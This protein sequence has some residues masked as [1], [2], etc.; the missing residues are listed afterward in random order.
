MKLLPDKCQMCN[1]VL[2]KV[3]PFKTTQREIVEFAQ[4]SSLPPSERE[5]IIRHRW[6]H[7]GL[8]CP[9][10]CTEIFVEH[11]QIPLPKMTVSESIAIAQTYSREH[12]QEF[13]KTHGL[14]SRIV[15]CVHCANF[16][17]AIVEGQSQTAF[18]RNPK[19]RPLRD[20][21]VI[22]ARCREVRIQALARAWWYDTG[23]EK[24]E[25]DYFKYDRLFEHAYKSVTGWSE[26]PGDSTQVQHTR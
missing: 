5:S 4:H 16:G 7:A 9:N 12:Y 11:G 23:R 8:H 20:S 13:V 25:C 19:Y 21:R 2:F 22:S 14:N 17:G 18:Y 1:S 24:P 10:G 6:M 3:V 26:Y 15:A